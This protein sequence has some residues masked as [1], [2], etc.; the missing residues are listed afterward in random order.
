MQLIKLAIAPLFALSFLGCSMLEPEPATDELAARNAELR[1]C[2]LE[3]DVTVTADLDADVHA[4]SPDDP[5]KTTICHI[6]PGNPANA[7]T[8]CV[9]NAA[10]RAHLENHGDTLG[11]C[12][13]EPPCEPPGSTPTSPPPVSS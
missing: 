11:P 3:D 1:A 6:P 5:R 2:D 4:C 10:V 12:V 7:H 13:S 8:L 9:G